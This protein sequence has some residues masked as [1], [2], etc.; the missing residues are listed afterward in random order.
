MWNSIDV[1]FN[2]T[3]VSTSN[4][5]YAYKAYI[6]TV[7]NNSASTKEYQLPAIGFTGNNSNLINW[8]EPDIETSPYGVCNEIEK[9]K[10]LFPL[11][12]QI[13]LIGYLQSDVWGINAAILNG[14]NIGLKMY[15][16][17]DAFRMMTY[18]QGIEAEVILKDITLKVCKKSMSPGVIFAHNISLTEV[19]DATYPFIRTETRSFTVQKGTHSITL[20]NPYQ[21][22]IPARMIL[23]MV[24]ADAKNGH[25]QRNPLKFQHFD[26]ASAG[27]YLN[28]EPI[29]RRPFLLDP[30]HNRFLEPMMELYSILGKMGEDRDIGLSR[31][32]YKDSNFLIPFDVQPTAAG[33]LQ[34]LAQRQGGHCRVELT[35]KKPLPCNICII[36]YAIFPSVIGIDVARNVKVYDLDKP[37]KVYGGDRKDTG[38]R[39]TV[40]V[41]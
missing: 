5:M 36:V 15:P 24:R 3:L 30:E 40:G 17:K 6:E 32:Q 21:S 13:D 38:A 12:T 29:P 4:T 7:L 2:D 9:R 14:I 10:E 41:V 37:F 34:Y 35:W 20:E 33:N 8:L 22:N 11:N 26:I 23:G 16:N 28:D 27:F 19:N 18:P 39:R 31:E 1:Q 25:Y